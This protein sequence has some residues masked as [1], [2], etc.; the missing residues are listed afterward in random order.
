M[1][2]T[3]YIPS[4]GLLLPPANCWD[5]LVGSGNTVRLANNT[6]ADDPDITFD[7]QP[8]CTYRVFG[9]VSFYFNET[10]SKGGRP[11]VAWDITVPVEAVMNRSGYLSANTYT[12]TPS[13]PG[14]FQPWEGLESDVGTLVAATGVPYG[15]TAPL[16]S[17]LMVDLFVAA[18]TEA[19]TVSL[20]WLNTT[21]PTGNA[22]CRLTT[23]S[24]VTVKEYPV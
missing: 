6:P 5:F 24:L 18:G 12:P 7:I 4:S 2:P 21:S 9:R 11:Y 3:I 8:G 23:E 14:A 10:A 13:A 22:T 15:D 17:H 1:W 20:Y 16:Y 19:G